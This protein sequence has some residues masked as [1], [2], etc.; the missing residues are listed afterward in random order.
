MS[1]R[2]LSRKCPNL[3]FLVTQLIL[4]FTKQYVFPEQRPYKLCCISLKLKNRVFPMRKLILPFAFLVLGGLMFTSCQQEQV[5][6]EEETARKDHCQLKAEVASSDCGL[7]LVIENGQRIYVNSTGGLDLK[8]G[9]TVELGFVDINATSQS[10]SSSDTCG[11][12]GHTES[13]NSSPASCYA[14]VG[15][16]QARLLCLRVLEE[17]TTQTEET[18]G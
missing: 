13:D 18:T 10:S 16:T 12:D 14:R 7:Y 6:P 15:A 1:G 5:L 9:M 4:I 17:P 8:E 2:I 3:C 11:T